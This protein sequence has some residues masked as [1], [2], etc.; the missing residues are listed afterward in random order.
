MTRVR[1]TAP[2]DELPHGRAL[3]LSVTVPLDETDL[4]DSLPIMRGGFGTIKVRATVG[5]T[6][7]RTSVF[8][9]KAGILL[10]VARQPSE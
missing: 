2:L 8:P 3:Y 10:L 4:L 1:F 5:C 6:S 9:T 7:W